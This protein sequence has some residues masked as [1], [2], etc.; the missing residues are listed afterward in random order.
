MNWHECPHCEEFYATQQP[1]SKH[2]G[3]KHPTET[4]RR[5]LFYHD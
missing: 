2:I 1:L 5:K 3:E 4:M